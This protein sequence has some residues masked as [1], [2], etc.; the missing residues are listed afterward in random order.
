MLLAAVDIN[1]SPAF[2]QVVISTFD[3]NGSLVL[4]GNVPPALAGNV[5]TFL[6]L[7]FANSGNLRVSNQE[8]VT[9]Q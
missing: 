1:G 2:L 3:A 9:F 6:S 5:I 7:G 4:S 8:A